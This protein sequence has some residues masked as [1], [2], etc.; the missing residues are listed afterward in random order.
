VRLQRHPDDGKAADAQAGARNKIV[1]KHAEVWL[2]SKKPP[3]LVEKSRRNLTQNPAKADKL[4][5]T[6]DK[7]Q[8]HLVLFCSYRTEENQS[9]KM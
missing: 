7:P 6:S 4:L 1:H 3:Q 2:G 8:G 9:E 5:V